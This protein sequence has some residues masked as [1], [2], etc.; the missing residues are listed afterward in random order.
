MKSLRDE[1]IAEGQL[2]PNIRALLAG[3]PAKLPGKR[4]ATF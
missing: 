2:P 1:Q 4:G 3:C